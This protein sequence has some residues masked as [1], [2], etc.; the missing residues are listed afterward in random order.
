MISIYDQLFYL[1]G[2]CFSMVGKVPEPFQAVR[3]KFN[4]VLNCR[5]YNFRFRLEKIA[6]E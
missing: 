3:L 6:A 2:G 1:G 4:V 5:A